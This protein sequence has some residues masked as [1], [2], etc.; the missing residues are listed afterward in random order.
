MSGSIHQAPTSTLED[1]AIAWLVRVQSDSAT[2]ADWRALTAW[3]E[4]SNDHLAAFEAAE[5]LSRELD[6]AAPAI[7]SA[8]K[9][10]TATVLVFKRRDAVRRWGVWIASVAAA[11]AAVVA[12][13]TLRSAYEGVP[14]TYQTGIGQTREIALADGTKVNLDAAS[15]M[16][17]RLG[18]TARRVQLDDAEAAFDVA[19]DPRRPFLIAVGDQQV[20]V[21]GTEFN[22]RH[23]DRN[24]AITVRR[25][26]VEVRQPELSATPVA[27]L[28]KGQALQHVVGERRS[29]QTAVQPDSAFA[30]VHGQLV[31]D[32][33]PLAE[34][35]ADL[36]RRYP[37][38]I[39]LTPQAAAKRFSGVLQLGD[40]ED[41]VRRLATYA[42]VSV[43]RAHGEITLR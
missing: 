37:R 16:T 8:I 28:T 39:H 20:R 19:K 15:K 13:P 36:N 42:D 25:G 32:D 33:R 31:V 10:V 17:V 34:V 22:I 41:V 23:R 1:E 6:D 30:W 5:A 21:V 24:L 29:V 35:V 11:A 4:M 12:A 26:V 18:W 9:P 43:D 27:T 38:A 2:E 14:V 7:E 3:L 40:Q